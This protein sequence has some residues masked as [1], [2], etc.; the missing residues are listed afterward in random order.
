MSTSPDF[1]LPYIAASQ[2]QPE[3][4]HNEAISLLQALLNGVI[5]RGV[6]TPPG[7][8][9]EGDAY[10]VGSA[11]TGEWTGRANCIAVFFGTGWLFVPG[12]DENGDP[13][14]MGA[15]QEG[16]RVYVRDED[17]LYAW[18]ETGSPPA[19]AWSPLPIGNAANVGYSNGT[20]GLAATN[21]QDALDQLAAVRSGQAPILEAGTSLTLTAGHNGRVI[22]FTSNSAVTVTLPEHDTEALPPGFVCALIKAGNG[23]VSVA[24]E[25]D[26]MLLALEMGSPPAPANTIAAKGGSAVITLLAGP[27]GSPPAQLWHLEGRLE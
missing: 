19:F 17:L 27:T 25:G 9:S 24:V 4:T 11:P 18:I 22:Y 2:A 15:R 8:P 1:G 12:N 16:M 10:I 3:V 7:S 20:S 5:D 6:N 23:D 14:A 21:V 26:D 13:I